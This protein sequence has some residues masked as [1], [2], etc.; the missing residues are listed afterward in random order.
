MNQEQY[1]PYDRQTPT[2]PSIHRLSPTS[3]MTSS[4]MK[5]SEDYMCTC[6]TG[7]CLNHL[8]G[9]PLMRLASNRRRKKPGKHPCPFPGCSAVFTSLHN[10][11]YHLNS[12]LNLRPYKCAYSAFGCIYEA[13][14]PT[15]AKRHN[16]RCKYKPKNN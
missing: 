2:L 3:Q 5:S 4:T 8:T 16:T 14:A 13:S 12:H 6:D 11:E 1:A 9:L 15:T 7:S 10:R